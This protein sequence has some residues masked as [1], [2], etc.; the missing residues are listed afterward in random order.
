MDFHRSD[1][2]LDRAEAER[3]LDAAATRTA[4]DAEPL[5]RLLSAAT[6]P[7]HPGEVAGEEA[8]LA[9]FR[10]ARAAGPAATPPRRRRGLTTGLAAWVAGVAAVATAGVAFAAV[11]RDRPADPQPPAGPPASVPQP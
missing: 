11:T 6:A 4:G 3:L 9:A 5:T 8:A 10:A 1:R 2:S 7:A